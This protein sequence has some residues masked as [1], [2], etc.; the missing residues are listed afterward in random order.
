[1]RCWEYEKYSVTVGGGGDG[2]SLSGA[3][4]SGTRDVTEEPEEVSLQ[5]IIN[6]CLKLQHRAVTVRA[7]FH[8]LLVLFSTDSPGCRT[9]QVFPQSSCSF[10]ANPHMKLP[11]S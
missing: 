3:G 2:K 7:D 8:D 5:G 6:L 10:T 9:G 11:C 4:T 1:M